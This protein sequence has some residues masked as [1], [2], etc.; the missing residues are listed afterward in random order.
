MVGQNHKYTVYIRYFWQENHQ[1][2]GHI[3]CLYT[4]LANPTLVTKLSTAGLLLIAAQNSILARACCLNMQREGQRLHTPP[5]RGW[6]P[7]LAI[8]DF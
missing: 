2:Y 4:F 1:V 6:Y 7:L 5:A 8:L 3:R